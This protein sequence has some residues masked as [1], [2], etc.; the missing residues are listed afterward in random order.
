VIFKNNYNYQELCRVVNEIE[1]DTI[2]LSF[3]NNMYIPVFEVFYKE[4]EKFNLDNLLI[5]ALDA[6]SEKKLKDYGVRTFKVG[7]DIHAERRGRFW[8]QRFLFMEY[9]FVNFRK[10]IL[11]TDIDCIWH[12]NIYSIIKDIDLD[13]MIS[14]AHAHPESIE[15]EFGFVGCMGLFMCKYNER[16][17]D[18]FKKVKCCCENENINNDQVMINNYIFHNNSEM[19]KD[20]QHD[21]IDCVVDV[22]VFKAGFISEDIIGRNYNSDLYCHHPTRRKGPMEEFVKS[23]KEKINDKP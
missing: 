18:F 22:D 8:F 13:F 12:K 10:N 9:I 21:V 1:S 5:I 11:G 7:V 2:I 15:R 20:Y 6:K 3:L 17:H 23:I 4:I 19:N 14:K 16:S